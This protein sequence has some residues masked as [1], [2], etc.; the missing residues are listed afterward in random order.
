MVYW[1][2]MLKKHSGLGPCTY[3]SLLARKGAKTQRFF[4]GASAPLCAYSMGQADPLHASNK[5]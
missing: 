3:P 1:T 5:L 4:L 2:R